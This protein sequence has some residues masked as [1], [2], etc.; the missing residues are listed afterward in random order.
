ML[1]ANGKSQIQ[2][3]NFSKIANKADQNTQNN[4]FIFFIEVTNSKRKV[5]G[6]LGHVVQTHVCH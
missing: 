6:K 5:K 2:G 4:S 3:E 1:M